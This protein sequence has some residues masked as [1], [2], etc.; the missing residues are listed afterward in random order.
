MGHLQ[1]LR[2]WIPKSWSFSR[3]EESRARRET[4]KKMR[5]MASVQYQAEAPRRRFHD[6]ALVGLSA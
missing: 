5:E 2:R 6:G 4:G 3:D 1:L